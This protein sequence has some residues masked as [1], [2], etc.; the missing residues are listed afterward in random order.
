MP[1]IKPRLMRMMNKGWAFTIKD[2]NGDHPK[3]VKHVSI[4]RIGYQYY[5]HS[6]KQSLHIKSH[7]GCWNVEFFN[8]IERYF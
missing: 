2:I 8:R 6:D 5:V 4:F 7:D 1:G 3:E